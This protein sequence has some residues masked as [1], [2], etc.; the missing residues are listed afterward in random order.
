VKHMN[1]DIMQACTYTRD[2]TKLV[3][4]HSSNANFNFQNSS[5]ANANANSGIYFISGKS[6]CSA[7]VQVS[8][9]IVTTC[10]FLKSITSVF[11]VVPTYRVTHH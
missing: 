2:V 4:L 6:E 11:I 1:Q 7:L 8:Y 10:Y 5:I 9:I 3:N